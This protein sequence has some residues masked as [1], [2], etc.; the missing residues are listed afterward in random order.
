MLV[1]SKIRNDKR[2][3]L[4]EDDRNFGPEHSSLEPLFDLPLSKGPRER[5]TTISATSAPLSLLRLCEI[6]VTTL[7][8]ELC[9]YF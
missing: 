6:T 9:Y 1:L 7:I 8:I 4:G 3:G 5:G 2:L